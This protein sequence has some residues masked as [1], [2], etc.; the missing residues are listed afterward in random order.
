MLLEEL[1]D[2]VRRLAVKS[3]KNAMEAR[4]YMDEKT[5]CEYRAENQAYGRVL[6][7]I[8]ELEHARRE[9]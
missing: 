4:R 9:F 2:A 1:K 3:A 5:E 6:D 8:E 7:L